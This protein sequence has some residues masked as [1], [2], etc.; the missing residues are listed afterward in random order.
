[1]GYAQGYTPYGQ[2][3]LGQNPMAYGQ[4]DFNQGYA[5]MGQA[6]PSQESMLYGQMRSAK[7]AANKYFPNG[8]VS[9]DASVFE[10]L[11][12]AQDENEQQIADT[13][14]SLKTLRE[15]GNRQM[16]AAVK[17]KLRELHTRIWTRS[18]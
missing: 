7:R 9:F 3:G 10:G 4:M 12:K 13:V 5:Q 17:A 8:I 1:M 2:T 16:S 15:N 14:K 11:F 18:S 6:D